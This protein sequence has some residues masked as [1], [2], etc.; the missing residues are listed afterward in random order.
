MLP[1]GGRRQ[2]RRLERQE[3]TQAQL[4]PIIARLDISDAAADVKGTVVAWTAPA[5]WWPTGLQLATSPAVRPQCCAYGFGLLGGEF[6]RADHL[7]G[8]P[9]CDGYWPKGVS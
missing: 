4:E 8:V 9:G 5:R 1:A 3:V 7:P 6:R 2:Q